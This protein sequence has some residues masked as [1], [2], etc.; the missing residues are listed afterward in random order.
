MDAFESTVWVGGGSEQDKAVLLQ[1]HQGI[2]DTIP[3]SESV[4]MSVDLVSENSGWVGGSAMFWISSRNV[5]RTE[6]PDHGCPGGNRIL[7]I[8]MLDEEAGWAVGTCGL[9]MRF[10]DSGLFPSSPPNTPPPGSTPNSQRIRIFLG[11]LV[12]SLR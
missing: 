10:G 8:D 12:R 5:T 1:Y 4:V 7:D 6:L 2:W 3:L 9:I 11:R